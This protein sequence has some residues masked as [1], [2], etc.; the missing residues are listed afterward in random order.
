MP[1]PQ[2]PISALNT[3]E[4]DLELT[5]QVLIFDKPMSLDILENWPSGEKED[6]KIEASPVVTAPDAV[7][8]PDGGLAAWCVAFGVGQLTISSSSKLC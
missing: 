1:L 7:D 4:M 8:Y 2:T 3:V 6:E 5:E